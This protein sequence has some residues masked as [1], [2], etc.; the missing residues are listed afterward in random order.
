MYHYLAGQGDG[1]TSERLG[2][3]VRTV[4]YNHMPSARIITPFPLPTVS[5]ADGEDIPTF[6]S[7]VYPW[8]ADYWSAQAA[9]RVQVDLGPTG[10]FGPTQEH[11]EE[12]L[13]APLQET[14][15]RIAER[16]QVAISTIG[17]TGGALTAG[18]VDRPRR[19]SRVNDPLRIS[20]CETHLLGQACSDGPCR[21]GVPVSVFWSTDHVDTAL[22]PV[23]TPLTEVIR[24]LRGRSARDAG[25]SSPTVYHAL[26][27]ERL[28]PDCVSGPL[29][30]HLI[31]ADGHAVRPIGS[32]LLPFPF[33]SRP[34][35]VLRQDTTQQSAASDCINCLACTHYCPA[36]LN[37]S[38]LYHNCLAEEEEETL[39]LGLKRCIQCGV[40]SLVCPARLPLAGQFVA[41]LGNLE[42]SEP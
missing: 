15:D 39:K 38:L 13:Q 9:D 1:T 8:K 22:V 18:V 31:A 37:P 10:P 29:T 21:A 32:G 20:L 27:G 2:K 30:E 14:L 7:S 28:P 17:G 11:W 23:G 25:S 40:C 5:S 19:A 34:V 6:L 24:E 35:G 4:R 41:A 3:H 42:T 33:F 36:E 26:T 16:F 12:L